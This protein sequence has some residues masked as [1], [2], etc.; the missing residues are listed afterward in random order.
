MFR[1]TQKPNSTIRRAKADQVY[2]I[3]RVSF[4][5]ITI[6][7]LT[8]RWPVA[9]KSVSEKYF[10]GEREGVQIIF[11]V[12]LINTKFKYRNSVCYKTINNLFK[13]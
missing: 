6:D 8:H 10:Q 13:R 7:F 2:F 5:S 11:V 4:Y 9:H 3:G 12:V 1:Y